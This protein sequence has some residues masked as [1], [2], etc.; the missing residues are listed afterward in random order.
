MNQK[1]KRIIVALIALVIVIGGIFTFNYMNQD[2]GDK[3]ISIIIKA[4]NQEVYKSEEKTNAGTL[5]NLLKE[6]KEEKDIVL[7]Y[8]QSAYGMY[9]KGMGKDKLMKEDKAKNMFWTYN[10][11][12]NK[13][14]KAA[15]FCDGAD[16]VKIQDKDAFEFE[17]KAFTN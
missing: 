13:Q 6:M 12:N 2:K 3:T 8:E 1:T 16:S 4:D 10:S 14:C 5:A 9:I 7:D 11:S 17:L 15:G